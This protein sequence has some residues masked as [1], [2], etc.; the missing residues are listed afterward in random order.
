M[1]GREGRIK[2]K[3]HTHHVCSMTFRKWEGLAKGDTGVNLK[4]MQWLLVI[5][6]IDD[7][8]QVWIECATCLCLYCVQSEESCRKQFRRS[9]RSYF[10]CGSF[11]W[12]NTDM[13][14][15]FSIHRMG[16]LIFI[17]LNAEDGH[18]GP[19]APVAFLKNH[20]PPCSDGSRVCSPWQCPR[21]IGGPNHPWDPK[22]I[23]FLI[24][25]SREK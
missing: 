21:R 4:E 7:V 9:R 20:N 15:S 5:L 10:R 2:Y 22:F 11:M 18:L 12:M 8:G 14:L 17:S 16:S 1:G 23:L 3:T 13:H 6:P 25:S 19:A 24:Q